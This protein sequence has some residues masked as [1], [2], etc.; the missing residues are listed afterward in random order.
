MLLVGLVVG[1]DYSMFCVKRQREE[2]AAG[3]PL[4]DAIETAAATSDRSVL[5]SGLTVPA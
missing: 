2:R 3:Q 5:V 1:M 4:L